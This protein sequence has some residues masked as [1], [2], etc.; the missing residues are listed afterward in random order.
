MPQVETIKGRIGKFFFPAQHA[1]LARQLEVLDDQIVQYIAAQEKYEKAAA[2]LDE[3]VSQRVAVIV[4][5]MDPFEP[6][7]KQFHGIFSEEFERPEENLDAA[8]QLRMAM[9]GY[10]QSTDP[11]FRHLTDWIMN[12][13]GNETLKRAPVTVERTLYGRAQI[14]GMILFVKEVKRLSAIYEDMLA[15][16]K[17]EV[18]DETLAVEE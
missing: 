7:M 15:K 10:Q 1:S 9:W 18:F 4:S 6:L 12:S 2:H 3:K 13:Q 16:Q 14:S 11:A 17:I 5:K 8:G